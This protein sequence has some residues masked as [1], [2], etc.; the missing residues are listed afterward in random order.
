MNRICCYFLLLTFAITGCG[1]PKPE[2]V[3]TPSAPATAPSSTAA[4]TNTATA[5]TPLITSTDSV[6]PEAKIGTTSSALVAT[7]PAGTAEAAFQQ[8][9]IAFQE[10]HLDKAFDFLPASYQTDAEK[11][12]REFATKMDAEIWSKAFGAMT[13]LARV[14]KSQKKMILE[15]EPIKRAPAI[16]PIKSQWDA[17]AD[18]IH[19]VATSEIE[20]IDSLKHA[21]LRQLLFSASQLLNGVS[22]PQFGNV[23][24]K[25]VTS[26]GDTATLSYRESIDGESIQVEFVKVEGKW[27]SKSIANGWSDGIRDLKARLQNLPG[28][29]ASVKPNVILHL[30]G[31]NGILDKAHAAKSQEE[32]NLALIELTFSIRLAVLTA[33]EAMLEATTILRKG[34]DVRVEINRELTDDERTKLTQAVF[35]GLKDDK[36]DYELVASGGKT[37]CRFTPIPDPNSLVEVIRKHFEG[38]DIRLNSEKNTITVELK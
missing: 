20:N 4:P 15:F 26:D 23:S 27:L 13:K 18:R 14:M 35:V 12:V 34:N 25:T 29:V 5:S 22:L 16:D 24:V 28:Q 11:I 2:V 37:R 38:A 8:M 6:S 7:A 32:L 3:A 33:Q 21:D 9:L 17:I 19:E 10:G 31:I 1:Q 30:D 36:V